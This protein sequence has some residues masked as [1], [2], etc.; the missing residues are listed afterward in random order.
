MAEATLFPV[1]CFDD[2]TFQQFPLGDIHG[3]A[4]Y[5]AWPSPLIAKH[6]SPTCDPAYRTI[7]PMNPV[8]GLIT[9]IHPLRCTSGACSY[10]FPVVRVNTPEKTFATGVQ[11]S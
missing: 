4:R 8:L 10:Q 7:R 6:L 5:P 3:R 9:L 11:S 1:A 2:L